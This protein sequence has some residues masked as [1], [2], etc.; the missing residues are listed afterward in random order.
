MTV[1][2]T[3]IK[4]KDI[5]DV[6]LEFCEVLSTVKLLFSFRKPLL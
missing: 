2:W 1:V 3:L 4:S 6:Q 5:N